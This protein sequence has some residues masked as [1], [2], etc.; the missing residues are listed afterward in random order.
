[1]FLYAQRVCPE[2]EQRAKKQL[3]YSQLCTE[4]RKWSTFTDDPIM[5]ILRIQTYTTDKNL[6]FELNLHR[7]KQ[8]GVKEQGFKI[9]SSWW[10][11]HIERRRD[12]EPYHHIPSGFEVNETNVMNFVPRVIRNYYTDIVLGKHHREEP[13]LHFKQVLYDVYNISWKEEEKFLVGTKEVKIHSS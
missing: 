10:S 2:A 5:E 4:L 8:A 6:Q 13:E 11:W 3:S 1:M 12:Q 7:L 9:M